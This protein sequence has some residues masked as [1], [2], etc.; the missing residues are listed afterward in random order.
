MKPSIETVHSAVAWL[1]ERTRA[2][3]PPRGRVSTRWASRSLPGWGLG[4]PTSWV[5]QR[6]PGVG[7]HEPGQPRLTRRGWVLVGLVG[8]FV[9]LGWQYG[10]RQLNA[11]AAPAVVALLAGAVSVW[12]ANPKVVE[13][14]EPPSGVPG[15][16]RTLVIDI[17][18]AGLVTLG[19]DLADGVQPADGT[20]ER[21]VTLPER[22]EWELSLLERG[23]YEVD[24]LRVRIHGPL[25]LVESNTREELAVELPVYPRRYDLREPTATRG[26]L[27]TRSD[28]LDQEFDRIREYT[29]GDP[30]RRVDW[31][32]SAKHGD[33]H[34][35][36]FDERAGKEAVVVG[37]VAARGTDDEMA[38]AVATLAE[39][40][41]DAGL[42]VGVVVPAGRVD[43]GSG[44]AH[45]E[46]I[47]R[48]LARTGPNT[49]A[50]GYTV[51]GD[52][53]T[54]HEADILVDA[55]DP[56]IR[57]RSRDPTVRT[58]HGSYPLRELRESAGGRGVRP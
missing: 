15:E 39:S 22:V 46:Q 13:V 30:L 4:S 12:R 55:G 41:L 34:V 29:P 26:S 31:N 42:D 17:E 7:G 3:R 28:I 11:V 32:A 19:F 8:L 1:I 24:R 48:L 37:G 58:E 33:L 49:L 57:R 43:P 47:R 10:A 14:N 9:V 45:R 27:H 23:I 50:D 51:A 56:L 38:R 6:L 44:P 35:V 52:D 53:V 40:A 21:T 18:G 20:T 2:T 25:G 36:E 16:T 5:G 54:G